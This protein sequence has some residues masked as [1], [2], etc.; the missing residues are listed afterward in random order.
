MSTMASISKNSFPLK[1]SLSKYDLS[2]LQST[3]LGQ[4]LL[5]QDATSA[6]AKAGLP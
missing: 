3:C 2:L 1:F 4:V 5:M 6:A